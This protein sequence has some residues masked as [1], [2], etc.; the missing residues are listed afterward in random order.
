MVL[1]CYYLTLENPQFVRDSLVMLGDEVLDRIKSGAEQRFSSMDDAL[2]AFE[3]GCLNIHQYL[4]FRYTGEILVSAEEEEI[5]VT[6]AKMAGV[7][8]YGERRGESHYLPTRLIRTVDNP[9][10]EPFQFQYVYTTPGRVIY[11]K[12]IQSALLDQ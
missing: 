7:R 9:K 4:W 11:N 12:T 8:C 5:M 1:G 10:G 3:Q 6:D 2:R